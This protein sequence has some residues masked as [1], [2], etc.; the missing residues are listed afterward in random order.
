MDNKP[1]VRQQVGAV[2]G[3]HVPPKGW[4]KVFNDLDKLGKLSNKQM[5]QILVILCTKIEEYEE[6]E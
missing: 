1:T 6:H 5:I 4:Q 2:L 3:M